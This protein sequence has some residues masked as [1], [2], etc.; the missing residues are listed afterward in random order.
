MTTFKAEQKVFVGGVPGVEWEE[1]QALFDSVAKSTWIE[2][3]TKTGTA[4]VCY[5]TAEEAATAI[6]YLNNSALS[7][8]S[9]TCEAWAKGVKRGF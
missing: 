2:V 3:F 6:A 8:R 7:G 9:I 5:A 1:L 4:C